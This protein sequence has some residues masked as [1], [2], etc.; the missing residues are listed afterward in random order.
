MIPKET[1]DRIFDTARIDEVVGEFVSLKKRGGNMIGLCPF[2]NEKTPSFNVSPARGIY[3][4]FGCGKGGNSVNFIMEHE[5]ITYPEA[6]KWLAKKYN[7]EIEEEEVS[8]EQQAKDNERES[9]F[10]V[11]A[12]AQKHFT[13]NLHET[14]EGKAIALSYFHE[15]GMRPDIIEKFML[16]YSPDVWRDF[17][18]AALAAGYKLEYLVKAGLVIQNEE[19]KDKFFDRFKGRVMFPVH[20]ASGRIIAFGGRTLKTD[21]KVAKYIN[22]PETDIYHKSNVLY[23]LYFAKKQIISEDVCYLVEGYTD[24]TSMHQAGIENV[25]ASSGTALTVEQIR[26]IRRYTNN[27]TI[28]YDGDAAGIKASFRGID[29]ILEEGMN[30]RVLLFPDGD[31]PDSYS[32]KVSSEELKQFI[33]DNTKDFIS[34]KTQL[35]SKEV[36]NDPI[37]KAGLIREII[38]SVAKIPDS[39]TRS[40]YVKNCSYILKIDEQTLLNEL[41]K[42]RKREYEKKKDK[43]KPNVIEQLSQT[44][45]IDSIQLDS[46]EKEEDKRSSKYSYYEDGLGRG[47]PPERDIIRILLMYG[48]NSVTLTRNR[49]ENSDSPE[50][51][52]AISVT[53]LI[54]ELL[55]NEGGVPLPFWQRVYQQILETYR[56]HNAMGLPLTFEHFIRSEDEDLRM[57]VSDIL[58]SQYA[59]HHWEIEFFISHKDKEEYKSGQRYELHDWLRHN[60]YVQ[61]EDM[62]LERACYDAVFLFKIRRLEFMLR[63]YYSSLKLLEDAKQLLSINDPKSVPDPPEQIEG[64]IQELLH[65]VMNLNKARQFFQAEYH[66]A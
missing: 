65:Q 57:I 53:S 15:R 25:V 18:D 62:Q 6:L 48:S 3:K 60:I 22:S 44:G 33:K 14:E 23:G 35:L 31:D 36:G 34:F 32:K 59:V 56:Q 46:E 17:A 11:S 19:D 66:M 51:S 47:I 12:F 52:E 9:L 45:I 37:K 63:D 26:L 54:F 16:G 29:L 39:I 61:T 13:K 24:V 64:D 4:C 42:L 28:L 21:K 55:D 20:N 7:I 10:L 2:H 58:F 50:P 40:V 30:V 1:V 27:I 49:T 5:H 43:D 8:S 38:E 41:N